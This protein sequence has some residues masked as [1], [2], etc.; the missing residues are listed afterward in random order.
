MSLTMPERFETALD[1]YVAKS[2][3]G[4]GASGRVFLVLD[5]SGNS[6]AVKCLDPSL[7]STERIRRFKNEL[8]F[9]QKNTH[10]NILSI[11][12]YGFMPDGEIRNPFYVMPAYPSTLRKLLDQGLSPDQAYELFMKILAGVEEA[13][14]RKIWHRDLKPQNILVNLESSTLVVAD[15]GIAHFAEDA[16]YTAI[17]TQKSERLANFAYAAPEQRVKGRSVDHRADIYALGLML[18]ELFT[19]EIPQGTDFR[20][21]SLVASRYAYLDPAIDHMIKQDPDQRP[22]SVADVRLEISAHEQNAYAAREKAFRRSGKKA[23][24]DS[25]RPYRAEVDSAGRLDAIQ[26]DLVLSISAGLSYS[27]LLPASEKSRALSYLDD[28]RPGW[29]KTRKR[30]FLYTT[31]LYIL[32]KDHIKKLDLI[33]VDPEY[34]GYESIM[35]GTLIQ[36]LQ[37]ST[38]SVRSTQVAF[39]RIDRSSP[40]R[41]MASRVHKHVADP[42]QIL[43]AKLLI[44][45]MK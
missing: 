13:H 10:P 22:A 44:E 32:V 24:Q 5:S 40:A 7:I 8:V 2:V 26:Q 6:L 31:L 39:E 28:V 18:N 20:H 11:I 33:V 17:Q 43:T 30:V 37:N 19:G 35:K 1:V 14:Q 36:L 27:I 25:P 41:Q 3:L 15:F 34:P 4:E 45:L 9:S 23:R 16:L 29:N 12:D 42:D 38:I 21:I